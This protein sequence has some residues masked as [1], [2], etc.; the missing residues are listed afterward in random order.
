MRARN[1][2]WQIANSRGQGA[3]VI[4]MMEAMKCDYKGCE[5]EA[6]TGLVL[7]VPVKGCPVPEHDPIR[8]IIWLQVC[9][10]HLK[11]ARARDFLEADAR[12]PGLIADMAGT[13]KLAEPDFE[14]AFISGTDLNG[15]EWQ[16]LKRVRRSRQG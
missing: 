15:A 16:A 9:E 1:G 5:A 11:D 12:L 10:E 3:I 13:M 6:T 7:N 8:I 2:K 4:E 14:R